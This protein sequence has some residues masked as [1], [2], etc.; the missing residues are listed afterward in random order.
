MSRL[1]LSFRAGRGHKSLTVTSGRREPQ[2]E[3][4]CCHITEKSPHHGAELP[5]STSSIHYTHAD[6][7]GAAGDRG[8]PP[9]PVHWT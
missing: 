5:V 9:S 4:G 6:M 8:P 3:S 7:Q 2:A 1:D